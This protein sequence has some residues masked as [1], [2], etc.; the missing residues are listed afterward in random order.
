MPEEERGKMEKKDLGKTARIALAAGGASVALP[1][2]LYLRKKLRI[3]EPKEGLHKWAAK[4][5][6][7]NKWFEDERKDSKLKLAIGAGLGMASVYGMTKA[8][9]WRDKQ[10]QLGTMIGMAEALRKLP[11][12][13]KRKFLAKLNRQGDKIFRKQDEIESLKLE[14]ILNSPEVRKEINKAAALGIR[15]GLRGLGKKAKKLVT[16][17]RKRRRKKR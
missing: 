9:H 8:M 16:K 6:G 14:N 11:P 17:K 7:S 4:Q 10:V 1:V 12:R 13:K 15:V 5:K 3:K 2:L